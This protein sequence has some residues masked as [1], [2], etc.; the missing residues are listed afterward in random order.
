[1]TDRARTESEDA[2]LFD[3]LISL[4]EN[5]RYTWHV[6]ARRLFTRLFPA[7]TPA[8]LE[9]PLELL[10]TLGQDEVM[11]RL[12]QDA[13]VEELA[14][15]ITADRLKYLAKT[16]TTW[17][18]TTHADHPRMEVAYFAAEF[19]LSD[20]LP[21]Y[22]GGLGAIAAEQLKSASALG[23]PLV[24]VGLLYRET[25]HQWI[26]EEGIQQESWKRLNTS[27]IPVSLARDSLG[28]PLSVQIPFPDRVISAQIWTAPVGRNQIFLLDTDVETN[29]PADR[30]ITAR[31]YGGDQRT[32][33]QQEM[34][35]GVGGLRALHLMGHDPTVLH[36]NEG[37]TAFA[38]LELM[39]VLAKRHGLTFDEARV[40]ASSK[41]IFTTHT[42]VAAGHDYF[43]RQLAARYLSPFADILKVDL[44]VLLRLGR[45]RPEDL[46]DTFCPTVFA[47]RLSNSRNG[48]SRLHGEVTRAQ[49]SGLWPR[50]PL[51]EVPIGHVTNGI[52]LQSWITNEIDELLD[53]QLGENWRRTPGD[54]ATWA[55]LLDADDAVLWEAKRAARRRLVE[56]TRDRR[57]RLIVHRGLLGPPLEMADRLLD[58]DALTIGFV[59]R[60]VAYKR[61][62]LFMRDPERL[63]ALLSNPDRPVQ[64]VFGG[65]AHPNDEGGK[66]LLRSVV[67][68]ASEFG[69]EDRVCFV[70]DFDMPTDRSLAQGVD[71]WLNTPRRPL[72]ACGIGGMKSGANGALNLSTL[73]GWWDEVWNDADPDAAPIGW[74]IG[75][76]MPYES[77][78][79][80]DDLDAESF[81]AT[82]ED[83]VVPAFYDR[84]E[85]GIPRRWLASVR[86]SMATLAP[87]WHSH[88]MVQHYVNDAYLPAATRASRLES[89][90][91]QGARELADRLAELRRHWPELVVRLESI[92]IVDDDSG[93]VSIEV[94]PGELH[95]DELHV[96][97][98]LAPESDVAFSLPAT[99]YSERSGILTYRATV[100]VKQLAVSE[101]AARV[102]PTTGDLGDPFVPGL[103]AWSS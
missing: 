75:T 68:F 43:P 6:G 49:W 44:E 46:D 90:D 103:I 11:E 95:T 28:R 60:F 70:E 20:S 91:A 19:A 8:Q 62:T 15:R 40:L 32:R 22:A 55:R 81:Y 99:L 66:L 26:D 96:E 2:L 45:Y 14:L 79:V 52:H 69:L 24:G 92:T 34:V 77:D 18:P 7:A 1:M 93:R 72:E 48:V 67:D 25:S 23:V 74:C 10:K 12:R 80:Q 4:A 56:S 61:P 53:C 41:V 50:V 71:I 73:D 35:L 27:E 64:I 29:A 84:D 98:W 102:L 31:L 37:H 97:V 76:A 94:S 38:T 85:A 59:G 16:P 9:W 89:G 100:P 51:H 78:D 101:V 17:Y 83:L 42:P 54:P 57:R 33:I 87:T 65:K 5:L 88:R 21:I 47:M 63:A 3:A 58:P 86:R 36:L 30:E 13:S 39:A 82:L